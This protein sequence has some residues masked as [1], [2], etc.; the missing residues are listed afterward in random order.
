MKN[1]FIFLSFTIFCFMQKSF[2]KSCFFLVCFKA[3]SSVVFGLAALVYLSLKVAKKKNI[4][5]LFEVHILYCLNAGLLL[6]KKTQNFTS[7]I[8]VVLLN[9]NLILVYFSTDQKKKKHKFLNIYYSY[10]CLFASYIMIVRSHRSFVKLF[11]FIC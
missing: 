10:V 7:V 5:Y 8:V 9:I 11:A 1:H 2:S 4:S 6:Q 3:S